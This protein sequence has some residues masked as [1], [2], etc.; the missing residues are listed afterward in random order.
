[1]SCSPPCCKPGTAGCAGGT[2]PEA[3]RA[4]AAAQGSTNLPR[5]RRCP[6]CGTTCATPARSYVGAHIHSARL[7]TTEQQR[8]VPHQHHPQEAQTHFIWALHVHAHAINYP[9]LMSNVCM[10]TYAAFCPIPAISLSA[11]ST[12]TLPK[13]SATLPM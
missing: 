13:G 11:R 10:S 5:T 1:M 7:S 12:L 9:F 6:A 4:P 2:C 3:A 8:N